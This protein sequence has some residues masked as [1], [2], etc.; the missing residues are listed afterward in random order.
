MHLDKDFK[1]I[2]AAADDESSG[3]DDG[4]TTTDPHDRL[5]RDGMGPPDGR[6]RRRRCRADTRRRDRRLRGGPAAGRQAAHRQR[7]G[8][9]DPAHFTTRI[10]NPYLPMRPGSRWVYRETDP[11][12]TRQRVVVTVTGRTKLIANGVTARVVHDVASERGKLVEVTDDWYAQDTPATSGTSARPPRST[13]TASPS[14]RTGSFEA[15]VDGAQAGVIM[16]A[17]PRRGC[18]TGRSTTPA[19][20]RT[21]PGW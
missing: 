13:R 3:D 6:T 7:A 12:G 15:G 18:A 16:P 2:A 11:D 5:T 1:V 21:G 9:L 10:T 4:P 20:P 19:R 17:R 8:H 14:R